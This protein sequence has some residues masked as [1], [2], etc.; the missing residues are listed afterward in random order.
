LS[1]SAPIAEPGRLGPTA[2]VGN[3]FCLTKLD[4]V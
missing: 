2:S 3:F 4:I 1:Y